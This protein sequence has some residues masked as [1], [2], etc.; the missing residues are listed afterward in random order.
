MYEWSD[1]SASIFLFFPLFFLLL[2]APE[3]YYILFLEDFPIA[4]LSISQLVT[5]TSGFP[6]CIFFVHYWKI[7][8]SGIGIRVDFSQH[9]NILLTEMVVKAETSLESDT[10]VMNQPPFLEYDS[11]EGASYIL[12]PSDVGEF[13]MI[14]IISSTI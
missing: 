4:I 2:N 12:I 13:V 3:F 1:F 11:D 9:L 6:L 8:S 7:V 14:H 10:P 5:D